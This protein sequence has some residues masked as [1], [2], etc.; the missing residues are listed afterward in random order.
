MFWRGHVRVEREELEDEGD[1]ALA[2][3][4]P[5]HV[6]VVEQDA[7]AGDRLQTGD[8]AQRGRLAAARRAEQHNELAIVDGQVYRL[9]GM[10]IAEF[11]LYF[12]QLNG[13]H[14]RVRS[15]A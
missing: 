2:G 4:R 3:M 9:D 12:L 1:V 8:H 5:G 13:C 7:P 11:L 6:A 10:Q 15:C 14:N